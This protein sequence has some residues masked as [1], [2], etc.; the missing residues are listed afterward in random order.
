M[1][2]IG[3]KQ[4]INAFWDSRHQTWAA[5]VSILWQGNFLD[6]CKEITSLEYGAVT[7]YFHC[8]T[9]FSASDEASTE[10]YIGG[11]VYAEV[12]DT[13][14]LDVIKNLLAEGWKWA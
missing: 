12:R 3:D 2:V 10:W 11:S 6:G 4:I 7:N 14:A 1:T 9:K 8:E 13:F 5:E